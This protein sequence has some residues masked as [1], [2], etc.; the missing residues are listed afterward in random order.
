MLRTRRVRSTN[1]PEPGW[2]AS[3][4]S[5]GAATA[6][7]IGSARLLG[8]DLHS[9]AWTVLARYPQGR[10]QRLPFAR[11][12]PWS[13]IAVRWVSALP[14]S[15]ARTPRDQARGVCQGRKTPGWWPRMGVR[16]FSNRLHSRPFGLNIMGLLAPMLAGVD[17]F[18]LAPICASSTAPDHFDPEE[19]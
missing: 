2:R 6:I 8:L 4:Q 7:V 11:F 3:G 12:S 18:V 19:S 15:G 16:N 14:V 10:R 13:R 5:I 17:P 9:K 1:R